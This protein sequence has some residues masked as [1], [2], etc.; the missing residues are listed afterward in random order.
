MENVINDILKELTVLAESIEDSQMKDVT[1]V[2]CNAYGKQNIFLAGAGRSGCV[3]RAFANRLMHLGFNCYMV[4]DITTVPIKKD[5]VLF[6][7][8]GSGKTSSLVNI[9]AKAK[10]IGAIIVT[11]TLQKEGNI[12]NMS[13][14]G[15]VLAGTTRLQE[16]QTFNSIQPIGS[17]FE[18][19]S[20]LTCDGLIMMLKERL[21]KSNVDLIQNHANLE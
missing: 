7:V 8:S 17:S 2:L 5:D 19:L 16:N 14:A 4:G 15:I 6:I 20:F 9:A 3:T 18:Q 1:D 13:N 10:Q 21:H 11:I 12:F